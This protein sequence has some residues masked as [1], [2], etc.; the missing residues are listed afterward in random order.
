MASQAI[1]SYITVPAMFAGGMGLAYL[2]NRGE[3]KQE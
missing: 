2:L 1:S 3:E